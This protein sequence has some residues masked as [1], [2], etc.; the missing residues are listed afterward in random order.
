MADLILL[1]GDQTAE[2]LPSIE[3]L[4]RHA[5][6]SSTLRTFLL[7]STDRLRA[8]FARA[9]ASYRRYLPTSFESPLE[10]ATWASSQTSGPLLKC[11]PALSA[12]LLCVAQLGH[13]IVELEENPRLLEHK[14]KH[15]SSTTLL[16]TCT[17]L[18]ATIAVACSDNLAALLV[19]ADEVVSLAFHI[20]LEAVRRTAAIDDSLS[21]TSSWATLVTNIADIAAVEAALADFNASSVLSSDR[22]AYISARGLTSSVITISGPPSTT[23]AL[24]SP[25]SSASPAFDGTKLIPLG[26]CAAF[27][28]PH[29]QPISLE[30]V[31]LSCSL[32]PALAARSLRSDIALLSAGHGHQYEKN[33]SFSDALTQ[34]LQDIFQEPIVLES[35]VASVSKTITSPAVILAA[36]GPSNSTKAIARQLESSGTSVVCKANSTSAASDDSA[37]SS[38]IPA[39]PGDDA[40]AIVGMASRL[41]GSE[42]LEEFWEVLEK[43]L[44]LH[45]PIRPDRF[46]V[47]SHCDITGQRRNTSLSKYGVF[48]D[49]PGYFDTRLFNMSPREAAQTDPQHRLLLLTTYEALEMAGYA[50]G[51]T[52]STAAR[53]IGS[54]V[55]Q[56]S[57]DYRDVNA[58]Q[59]VDTYFITGGIR[60]FGPGRLNYHF[61]WEGPSYSVDTACSSSAASIQLACSALLARECDTAVAGGANFLTAS[62]LFAGLSRGSFLSK[63][64]GCKTFDADADGYVRADG[65]AVI[66]LKRLSDAVADNDNILAV[67]R[68]AVTNHSAEAVSITH[69][70]AATQERLFRAALNRAGL[71]PHDID[72]AELHGTGTQAGDATES[73]SVTNVLAP[74]RGPAQPLYVGTVKPN[75]GHGEAASGVTSLMKAVLML[76]NN[77][78]PPHVGIKGRINPKLPP[79]QELNTHIAFKMTPFLPRAGGDGK[80]RILINNFDAAGGNTSIIMEDAPAPRVAAIA[81]SDARSHHVIAVSGRTVN[82]LVGNNQRLLEYVRKN[83]NTKLADLSYTTTARRIHQ[84]LRQTHVASTLDGLVASLEAAA[85]DQEKAKKARAPT[86]TPSVIFCF[87]GQGSQYAGMA[88]ELF[89]SQPTFRETLLECD[90]IS[91]THGFESFLSVLTSDSPES[92]LAGASPVQVQLA[93]VSIELAL[94]ALW[95]S[96]GVTPAAVIGHSLGE[97]AALC[98][99]G[100]LSLSDCLYLVGRRASLML[101]S[102]TPGTQS[103]LAL[104]CSL[105]DA[106]ALLSSNPAYSSCEIACANGPSS[107]VVSGP[108]ADVAELQQATSVKATLLDVQFAFHSAQMDPVITAFSEYTAKAHY[109]S[110]SIPFAS[111]LLGTVVDAAEETPAIDGSYLVRQM[112]ERVRFTDAVE[113]LLAV[114]SIQSGPSVWIETGPSP[115]CLGLARSTFNDRGITSPLLLPSLKRGESDW[116]MFSQAV[117]KAHEAGV[118]VDWQEYHA[119]FESSL[120]LLELPNYA[121][122]LK[123]YWIQYR[124][125]WALRKGDLAVEPASSAPEPKPVSYPAFTATTGLHRIESQVISDNGSIAVSFA[126]D[127]IEPKLNKALRGHLVNE[128]GLCPSSVL[129][130]MALTASNYIRRLSHLLSEKSGYKSPLGNDLCLDVHE[131]GIHKPL[132]VQPGATKQTI[133]TAAVWDSSSSTVTFT[134]SSKDGPDGA[135]EDHA[136]C[137]A[138]FSDGDAWKSLW[139]RSS[140]LVQ[141][142]MDQLVQAAAS[143][144]A[145]KLLRPMV[146]KLFASFVDYA[147]KYQGLQ[148]V[149]MDSHQLEAAANVKFL[150]DDSDG[151][152]TCS[153]YWI[154]GFAHLSGFI[155]NGAD[156]TPADSV[157]ISHG[158]G[159]MKFTCPFSAD[160]SYRSYVRMQEEIG[161]KGVFSGDVFFFEGD[162]VI[163]M[164]EDLKFQ[165][166]KRSILAYLLPSGAAAAAPLKSNRPMTPPPSPPRKSVAA[167]TNS[168][169]KRQATPKKAKPSRSSLLFSEIL[170]TV[171]SEVGIEVGELTD[172]AWFADLG[173]DSLLA[174]SIT[175]RLSTLMGHHLPATLFT[176]YLSVSQLRTYFAGE[177]GA[178]HEPSGS[179]RHDASWNTPPQSEPGSDDEGSDTTPSPSVSRGETPFS[180]IGQ[181]PEP[182]AA[183]DHSAELFRKI[184]SQEV[185]V[186]ASE[187]EDDT[188]L[189]DLG[190]DSLLSLS[191]LG[192]IK[193]QT[194]RV[195]PSSFL[196]DHPTLKD[197]QKVLGGHSHTSPQALAQ[198][199]EIVASR[200]VSQK[201]P[202]AKH[203]AEAILLQGSPSSSSPALFLLPDGSGSASSYVGLP[204][205][206]LKGAVYGLNSPFLKTPEDFTLPLQDVAS[207]YVG[208]IRRVQPAGPYHLGGW[209]IGGAYAFEVAS[210][211]AVRHG[212]QINSL[213]LI[214]APCPKTLPPLPAQTIDLLDKIGAFDGLKGRASN[215]MRSGVRDHFA[216]SVNALKQYK[217]VPMPPQAVP[218]TVSVLWA[219][220]GVWETVGEDVR[221]QHGGAQGGINAAE[222]W[223]MDPRKDKGPNGWESLLPRASIACKIVSGDHFTIMRRPGVTDLGEKVRCGV[224]E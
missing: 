55:G 3:Q 14:D 205:M 129:G 12:A 172:D 190:V 140:Y 169:A 80:R 133:L 147:E 195:L 135:K 4:N 127:A 164:C 193:A 59:D 58:S 108:A 26:I 19:I 75:L 173:V 5:L 109:A 29:L 123:N 57:D 145:H 66:V 106:E 208:E 213:I 185:G 72:Y 174:I 222:D 100:V 24:F 16:G 69:P 216:G 126:T 160:K 177:S 130:D 153:P 155:L 199:V 158:W 86:A 124:G 132:L 149:Y 43:G 125:D 21:G 189:A 184:I 131:M 161:S 201:K 156:T 223:I 11:S 182:G 40:I 82:A 197:I 220:D 211:L 63:T 187:I 17:G 7:R 192:A 9:P 94:A 112:R 148:E 137:K 65:V 87:T 165:R 151:T 105:A 136:H 118:K 68:A 122:D 50:P 101:S 200:P 188:L 218:K 67:V 2:V 207:M 217:P 102:C 138:T 97:Y 150:T 119:A 22:K 168:L 96:V 39:P 110:P 103:M 98:T 81:G 117:A 84:G 209:S 83:P 219:R 18:L 48:I 204:P 33:S 206:G 107:T 54:F 27:H 15:S 142:R 46:D 210:Q 13:I 34:A 176:E 157:F 159:S 146:Y 179:S 144:R 88:S 52:P 20:G 73:R 214:D 70:H 141:G 120:R 62:D 76:R 71:H 202:S 10:L 38:S 121:F 93:I 89:A 113:S 203:S 224:S 191:I 139:K 49:R 60:A 175:A 114:K 51:R 104:A 166:V 45:E 91:T 61:G 183:R 30:S 78:I 180:S 186:D 163:A 31:L 92:A 154:D 44:D 6:R 128:A 79:F 198:A 85:R 194:G 23:S 111:T 221:R 178:D 41:P 53:R 74:G 99:A 152:F 181:T 77:A 64:G 170:D 171:A 56:T 32:S 95:K 143:G 42:T 116:K 162:E 215:T 37:S 134:F 35:A 212:E 36:F 25:S 47:D 28:A 196:I 1:F 8:S 115:V 167:K 90:R